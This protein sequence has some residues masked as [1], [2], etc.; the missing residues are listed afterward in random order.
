MFFRSNRPPERLKHDFDALENNKIALADC[1]A[2]S[3]DGA[4]NVSGIFNAWTEA[5]L[6]ESFANHVFMF[7][8]TVVLTH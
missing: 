6:K 3:T 8:F 2:D 5:K 1:I 4:A 7:R